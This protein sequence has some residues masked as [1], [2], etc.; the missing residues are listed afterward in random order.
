M[1]TSA[2]LCCLSIKLSLTSQTLG[3]CMPTLSCSSLS[4]YSVSGVHGV[5]SNVVKVQGEGLLN[6]L[7]HEKTVFLRYIAQILNHLLGNSSP[8]L[9]QN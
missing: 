2:H 7:S 4:S 3:L 5:G 9:Q 8:D 1:V 6:S